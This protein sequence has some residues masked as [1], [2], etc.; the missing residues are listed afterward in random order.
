MTLI[1]S[2]LE[3]KGQMKYARGFVQLKTKDQMQYLNLGISKSSYL[4]VFLLMFVNFAPNL[5]NLGSFG[6]CL[7]D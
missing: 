6:S 7:R 1:K 4:C 3:T 5:G 2:L